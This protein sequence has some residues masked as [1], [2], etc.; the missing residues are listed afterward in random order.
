MGSKTLGNEPNYH[1]LVLSAGAGF[2]ATVSVSNEFW[3]DGTT[4][5]I[6]F[7]SK[8]GVRWDGIVD[9]DDRG[10]RVAFQ[11]NEIDAATIPQGI[12]YRM[13]LDYGGAGGIPPYLWY[14]GITRREE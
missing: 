6:V 7:P 1:T 4:C 12:N 8:P 3:P 2:M 11:V 10:S 5:W 13:Y 14:R 9:V